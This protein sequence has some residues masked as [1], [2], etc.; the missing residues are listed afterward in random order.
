[1]PFAAL[2]EPL[3][4]SAEIAGMIDRGP[5]AV[6]QPAHRAREHEPWYGGAWVPDTLALPR[7]Q[8]QVLATK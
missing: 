7:P 1:M 5:S 4:A 3:V 2:P 6:R 8:S